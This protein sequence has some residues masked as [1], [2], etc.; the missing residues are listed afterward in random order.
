MA[1]RETRFKRTDLGA[2]AEI[3][4]NSGH[5]DEDKKRSAVCVWLQKLF[6]KYASRTTTPT[7]GIMTICF[8]SSSDVTVTGR[9]PATLGWHRTVGVHV[10]HANTPYAKYAARWWFCDRCSHWQHCSNQNSIRFG[11]APCVQFTCPPNR[12]SF[13][14]SAHSSGAPVEMFSKLQHDAAHIEMG[15]KSLRAKLPAVMTGYTYNDPDARPLLERRQS[16][17]DE[18]AAALRQFIA[19]AERCER[20]LPLLATANAETERRLAAM[21]AELGLERCLQP[22]AQREDDADV[23]DSDGEQRYAEEADALRT[24]S[25][26]V[27]T[28]REREQ[29]GGD[30][31][32]GARSNGRRPSGEYL[33]NQRTSC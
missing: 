21:A 1:Q 12:Y 25:R 13:Q 24:D 27:D 17:A 9:R 5:N 26:E 8:R 10:V 6:R 28:V 31:K 29:A 32:Q 20:Q 2:A 30:D 33:W 19:G 11:L 3:Q 22:A 18:T 16:L 23:D 7:N 14:L 15:V 4:Q